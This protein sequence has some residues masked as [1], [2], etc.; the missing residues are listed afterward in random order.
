MTARAAADAVLLLHLAFIV[1]ATFG[2]LLARAWPRVPMIQLPSA[3]WAFV[4][5]AT[6]GIC[7]LTT[8]ENDLRVRAGEAGYADSFVEQHVLGVIYPAGLTPD[9]QLELGLLVIGINAIV[10]TWLYRRSRR[11]SAADG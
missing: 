9:L 2:G 4:V 7:P 8:I 1:F 10:Y 11:R 6:G 5:E 3:L